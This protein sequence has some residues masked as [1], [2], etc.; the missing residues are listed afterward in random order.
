M[1]PYSNNMPP[2]NLPPSMPPPAQNLP[3]GQTHGEDWMRMNPEGAS[4]NV[5]F[6]DSTEFHNPYPPIEPHHIF[7]RHRMLH[8]KVLL[9]PWCKNITQAEKMAIGNFST[10]HRNPAEQWVIQNSTKP[11][12]EIE[13]LM[14]PAAQF[15]LAD[16]TSI[17]FTLEV[18]HLMT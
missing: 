5:G 17:A 13:E 12:F 8:C 7:D 18:F 3:P 9:D 6:Q 10:Y 16:R 14:A 15:G 4:P 2:P 11:V 1:D